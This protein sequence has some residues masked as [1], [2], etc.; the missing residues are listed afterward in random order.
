MLN[1]RTITLLCN[2]ILVFDSFFETQTIGNLNQHVEEVMFDKFVILERPHTA[3][4]SAEARLFPLRIP[5]LT[6]THVC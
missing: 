3:S 2:R 5:P 1:V 6:C 4:S